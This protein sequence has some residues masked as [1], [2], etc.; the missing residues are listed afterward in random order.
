MGHRQ[1]AAGRLW[2]ILVPYAFAQVQASDVSAQDTAAILK[3][4]YSYSYTFDERQIEGFISLFTED[5]EW[6]AYEK[7]ATTPSISVTGRAQIS[8]FFAGQMN[9]QIAQGIQ[10]RH[11]QTNTVLSH[12]SADRVQGITMVMVTWR[13]TSPQ[14]VTVIKHTGYY[15]DEFVRTRGQWR[16]VK[17]QSYVDE[18]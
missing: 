6:E 5:A 3:V 15:L 4:I 14:P 11:Y 13:L 12:L 18:E 7:G 9:D 8:A 10:S 1:V 17:R 2:L 16:F